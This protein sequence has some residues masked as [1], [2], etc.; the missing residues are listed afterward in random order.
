MTASECYAQVYHG[1]VEFSHRR[2]DA[3][4]QLIWL[5]PVKQFPE[6]QL[7]LKYESQIGRE[8]KSESNY[9]KAV[10]VPT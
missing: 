3:I 9:S 1:L 6:E 10:T 8:S 5:T 7:C 2:I 4:A